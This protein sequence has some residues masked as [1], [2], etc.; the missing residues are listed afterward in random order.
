MGDDAL[1]LFVA[2]LFG[3]A[4]TLFFSEFKGWLKTIGI[5]LAGGVVAKYLSGMVVGYAN[6]P[7]PTADH[8]EATAF[9]LGMSWYQL[10]GKFLRYIS[11]KRFEDLIPTPLKRAWAGFKG[12]AP[13][14]GNKD[15]PDTS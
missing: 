14:G 3:S 13:N 9:L 7:N 11:N 6:I 12:D 8:F 4:I 2:G 15:P 1:R 5:A 10:L